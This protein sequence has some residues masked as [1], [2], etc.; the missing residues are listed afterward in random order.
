MR[1][2]PVA[3]S[4]RYLTIRPTVMRRPPSPLN[5]PLNG[6]L[7]A[8]VDLVLGALLGP[9]RL[10]ALVVLALQETGPCAVGG[11]GAVVVVGHERGGNVAGVAEGCVIG[12]DLG[13]TKLLAGALDADLAVHHRTNRPVLGLDQAELVGLVAHAVEEVSTAVGGRG[14]RGRIRHPLHVRLAHRDGR[15]GGQPP[16]RRSR[17]R[18]DHG[19]PARAAGLRRQRRQLRDPRRGA[20]GRRQGLQRDR[21]A[22][23]GDRHRQRDVPA[24]GGLPRLSRRRRGDRPHGRRD[25]RPP[26]PGQL[27]ELGLPGVGRLRDGAGARGLAVGRAAPRHRDRARAGVGPRADRPDDHRARPGGRPGGAATPSR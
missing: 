20:R 26:V 12:V 24:R 18:G 5:R 27:P 2:Q 13:G 19:R 11:V 6:V 21:P 9:A 17:L 7:P 16:A 3:A 14:R 4:A 25:E 1:I 23:A 10:E 8:A 22:H 15:P